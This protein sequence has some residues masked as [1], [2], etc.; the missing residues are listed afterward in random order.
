MAIIDIDETASAATIAGIS[1]A[2]HGEPLFVK[3]DLREAD[4]LGDI[5]SMIG[6]R[7][8]PVRVL[9]NNAARDDRQD[10][11]DTSPDDWDANHAINL[12]PAFFA[13]QAAAPMMVAAGGGSIIN[14]S[15]IAWL[16]NMGSL[17]A[18][19]TAK[20]GLVGLT[21]SL[22][23]RLGPDKIRVNAVLP[24]MVL[25]ERQRAKWIT[26]ADID[27]MIARQCLKFSLEPH[28][29][30]APCSISPPISPPA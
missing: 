24:G 1:A 27:G 14:F 23:G 5:F 13:A 18:Y 22:A 7:L 8:G 6:D 20:A 29:M 3:A 9:V 19:A 28:H 4:R 26:Q 17:P 25:T 10:F 30:T 15:S 2:G 16:L 11:L 12:R 21:K